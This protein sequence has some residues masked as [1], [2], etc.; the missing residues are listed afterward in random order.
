MGQACFIDLRKAFDTLGYSILFKNL[1]VY[2]YR[3]LIFEGLSDFF[4][5][6]FQY[7]ETDN[8][9]TEKLQIKTG[10][11]RGSIWVPPFS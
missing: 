2:G 10:V 1:N 9:E 11:P 7:I 4:R 3:G 8:D 5:I 6:R